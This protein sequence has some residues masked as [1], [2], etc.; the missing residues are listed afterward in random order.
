M[1]G[2]RVLLATFL[3]QPHRPAR[4]A[5]PQIFDLHF[6]GGDARKRA[7]QRLEVHW[8]QIGGLAVTSPCWMVAGSCV[9]VRSKIGPLL[10]HITFGAEGS[11]G[12][13]GPT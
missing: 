3:V 2:H 12:K 10:S 6:Q 13:P 11:L 7:G 5:R 1:A 4:A 9:L 8:P